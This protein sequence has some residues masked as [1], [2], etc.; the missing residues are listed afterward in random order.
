MKSSNR[1][2]RCIELINHWIENIRRDA[3]I[4]APYLFV[5]L[6]ILSIAL[7]ELEWACVNSVRNKRQLFIVTNERYMQMA[8][9]HDDSFPL[10]LQVV[11]S[12][13]SLLLINIPSVT[14]F[15]SSY[16]ESLQS[17]LQHSSNPIAQRM[18]KATLVDDWMRAVVQIPLNANTSLLINRMW[19]F[20][21]LRTVSTQ[22]EVFVYARTEIPHLAAFYQMMY[23]F[24]NENYTL[25][26]EFGYQFNFL[27]LIDMLVHSQQTLPRGIDVL[28][29]QHSEQVISALQKRIMDAVKMILKN[30]ELLLSGEQC[31]RWENID[32]EVLHD[33]IALLQ[34]Y[35][36]V[37]QGDQCIL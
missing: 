19:L 30:Q 20:C 28:F 14:E 11:L 27:D 5:I 10:L 31:D 18:A 32:Q 34:R 8:T 35:S 36:V 6:S 13:R 4:T 24:C 7:T 9:S 29:I 26:G 37:K 2:Q 12:L 22:P 25:R 15:A 1:R 33:A 21:L 16:G 17:Y 23:S 3:G